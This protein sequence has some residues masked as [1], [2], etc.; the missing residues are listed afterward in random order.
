MMFGFEFEFE[1]KLSVY[2]FRLIHI[3]W[4]NHIVD[5]MALHCIKLLW[6]SIKKNTNWSHYM[7]STTS[8]LFRSG[9]TVLSKSAFPPN[10]M[11]H[12]F[13]FFSIPRKT[14][15]QYISHEFDRFEKKC[16]SQ[17]FDW[18]SIFFLHQWML[19]GFGCFYLHN[20]WIRL[21]MI[22]IW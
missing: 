10:E 2:G 21:L 12:N 14:L 15:W 1:L 20:R 19:Y 4:R 13:F 9:H 11:T 6:G 3:F 22:I 5:V 16:S 17:S 18:G 8:N 7:Q